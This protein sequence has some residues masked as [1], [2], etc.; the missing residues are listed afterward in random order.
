MDKQLQALHHNL[1]SSVQRAMQTCEA[2]GHAVLDQFRG[3]TKL[4]VHG[5]AGSGTLMISC[6]PG[7]PAKP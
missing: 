1:E 4:I 6:S 5:R 3:V 7:M 2:S